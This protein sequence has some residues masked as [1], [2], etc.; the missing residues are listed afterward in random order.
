MDDPLAAESIDDGVE[1]LREGEA[2]KT[3]T[4]APLST[5]KERFSRW[6]KIDS[7]PSEV[8]DGWEET[9]EM[10]GVMPGAVTGPRLCRFPRQ[11]E[12]Q[13]K[14]AAGAVAC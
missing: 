2:G 12:R 6:Q 10:V 4:S 5:R 3:D 13:M 7:A 8:D 1:L 9:E 14:K 11:A